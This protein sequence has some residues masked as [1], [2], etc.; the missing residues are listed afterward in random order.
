MQTAYTCPLA[1]YNRLHLNLVLCH[2]TSLD[3]ALALALARTWEEGA[4]S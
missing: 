4:T 2:L 3:L 1:K